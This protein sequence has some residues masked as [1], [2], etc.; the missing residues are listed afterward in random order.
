MKRSRDLERKS[1]AATLS[2]MEIFIFPELLY[3][4]MLANILR[5]RMPDQTIEVSAEEAILKAG[6]RDY[7]FPSQKGLKPQV[8]KIP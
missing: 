8:W 3:S 6:A 1:A 7:P 4:L 5:N 2:D